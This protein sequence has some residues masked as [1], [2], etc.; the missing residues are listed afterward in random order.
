MLDAFTKLIDAA[1]VDEIVVALAALGLYALYS[2]D[3]TLAL[4]AASAL[5]GALTPGRRVSSPQSNQPGE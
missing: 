3:N 2:G 4:V 5:A 1:A